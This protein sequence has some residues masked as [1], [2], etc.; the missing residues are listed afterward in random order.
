MASEPPDSEL[1]APTSLRDFTAVGVVTQ[2]EAIPC[3]D[4]WQMRVHVGGIDRTLRMYD[5]Y[6]P[7]TFVTLDAFVRHARRLGLVRIAANLEGMA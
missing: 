1:I 3:Q 6:E 4:G 7:R 5:A 2:A